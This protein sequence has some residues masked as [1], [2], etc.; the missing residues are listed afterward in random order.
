[1][2][3][4]GMESGAEAEAKATDILI[5]A[6][7]NSPSMTSQEVA[8]YRRRILT[9]QYQGIPRE[10]LNNFVDKFVDDFLLFGYDVR[11]DD[12]FVDSGSSRNDSSKSVKSE[13]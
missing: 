2:E 4:D 6:F 9:S 13:T 1:M 10:M 7:L 8:S 3:L 5:S 12:I 11:P